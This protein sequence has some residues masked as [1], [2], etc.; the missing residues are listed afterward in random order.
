MYCL[1]CD[2]CALLSAYYWLTIGIAV[3]GRGNFRRAWLKALVCPNFALLICL[4]NIEVIVIPYNQY[5]I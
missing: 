4:E 2:S 5:I 1:F 3:A